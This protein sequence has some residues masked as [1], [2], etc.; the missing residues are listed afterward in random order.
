DTLS[1]SLKTQFDPLGTGLVPRWIQPNK[2]PHSNTHRS[3]IPAVATNLAGRRWWRDR[4]GVD[5]DELA[6]TGGYAPAAP[7]HSTD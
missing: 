3:R 5:S 6:A 2:I 7:A 1:P 4:G